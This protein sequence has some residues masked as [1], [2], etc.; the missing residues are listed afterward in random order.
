MITLIDITFNSQ[1]SYPV[2]VIVLSYKNLP[3]LDT[4]LC[5]DQTAYNLSDVDR[6]EVFQG[7][8][9]V[10]HCYCIFDLFLFRVGTSP[11]W[12]KIIKFKAEEL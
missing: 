2:L 11:L 3:P 6:L 8:L 4:D 1:L 9:F 10:F 12:T 5:S 7:I